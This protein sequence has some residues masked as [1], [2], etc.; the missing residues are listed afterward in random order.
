VAP[1]VAGLRRPH[2]LACVSDPD[3]RDQFGDRGVGHGVNL[4]S[5]SALSE[6]VSK[7]ARICG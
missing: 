3:T 4:G 1:V 5:V 2:S 7:S 6:S